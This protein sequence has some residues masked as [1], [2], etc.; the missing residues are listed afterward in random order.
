M[1]KL[2]QK[3]KSG[4]IKKSTEWSHEDEPTQSSNAMK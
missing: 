4:K 2:I 3:K 1:R